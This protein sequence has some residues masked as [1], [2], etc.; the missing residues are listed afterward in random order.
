M[1]GRGYDPNFLWMW[2]TGKIS[3]MGGEQAANVLTSVKVK[4][5]EK[6]GENLTEEQIQEIKQPI[7]EKYEEQATPYYSSARLWDAGIIDL[8]DT[9]NVLAMNIST[10]L[11]NDIED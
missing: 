1:C 4:Q 7:L 9:R 6:K 3:V 5:L 8:V 11:N 10:A 2:P